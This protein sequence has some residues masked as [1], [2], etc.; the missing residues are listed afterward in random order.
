MIPTVNIHRY[1]RD[2]LEDM[3]GLFLASAEGKN[4]RIILYE[5]YRMQN[6]P[7]YGITQFPPEISFSFK[8]VSMNENLL[9]NCWEIIIPLTF[10]GV[11]SEEVEED[12]FGHNYIILTKK[13]DIIKIKG[14]IC[15]FNKRGTA[16]FF[17]LE[18]SEVVEGIDYCDIYNRV[19]IETYIREEDLQLS[20]LKE[21]LRQLSFRLK[22]TNEQE[23]K[24]KI[25]V[26]IDDLLIKIKEL[27]NELY[28]SFDEPI[29]YNP[30]FN[31]IRE[32]EKYQPTHPPVILYEKDGEITNL[33]KGK[34]KTAVPYMKIMDSDF[35]L[36]DSTR[37]NLMKYLK[38]GF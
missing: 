13:M 11:I 16:S 23:A 1:Y 3:N 38:G 31:K 26:E 32:R 6:N 9:L 5:D 29:D 19:E 36:L 27:E 25:A 4:L 15:S 22:K 28:Y 20:Y 24:N 33:L 30:I 2:L 10:V 34:V 14:K 21:H 18:P 7:F 12:V 35:L 17:D 8:K 37:L